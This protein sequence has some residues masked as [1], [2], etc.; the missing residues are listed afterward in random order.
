MAASAASFSLR[1]LSALILAPLVLAAL[2]YGWPIYIL[3]LAAVCISIYEWLNLTAK[4]PLGTF[5]GIGGILYIAACATCFVLTQ[6][7]GVIYPIALILAVWM[8][9]IGAYVSGKLIG[10]PRL[11]P[12]IS[13]N[14]TWAGLI[15][16]SVASAL[17]LVGVGMTFDL[18]FS[19]V[20]VLII[21]ALLT[22]VGQLGDLIVSIF[23]RKADVKD[24]GNLI[25][26]HGGL[27]D[28]IDALLLASPFFL[29][30]L[31]VLIGPL[32]K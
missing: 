17:T 7:Y 9:D 3:A 2:W 13:P 24:T 18:T 6:N 15:G 27:L 1:C 25:P 30:C 23:K 10:G 14:K 31:V 20:T 16:G 11:A 4:L 28:R 5:I 12:T 32:S 22:P 8:S 19:I 21:G 29:F 26:G